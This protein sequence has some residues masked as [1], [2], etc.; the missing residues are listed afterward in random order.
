VCL[1]EG[2]LWLQPGRSSF[3][4]LGGELG[5]VG[6]AAYFISGTAREPTCT[7]TRGPTDHRFIQ[8]VSSERPGLDKNPVVENGHLVAGDHIHLG[9]QLLAA[10]KIV[11]EHFISRTGDQAAVRGSRTVIV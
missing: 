10:I 4:G 3:R 11:D 5:K 8:T 2:G 9:E 1:N 6:R 7:P